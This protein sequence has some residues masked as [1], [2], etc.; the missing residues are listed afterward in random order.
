MLR[1]FLLTREK[2]GYRIGVKYDGARALAKRED[3]L[4]QKTKE[5]SR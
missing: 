2:P 3:S 5:S 4:W 1:L